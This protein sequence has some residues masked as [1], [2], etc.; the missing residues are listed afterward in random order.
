MVLL[1]TTVGAGIGL[2]IADGRAWGSLGFLYP[3]GG[4]F[5][6]T[7]GLVL[8]IALVQARTIV[9]VLRI[10]PSRRARLRGQLGS[11]AVMLPH[12]THELVW[13]TALSITAGI[14]EEFLFRGYLLWA[15]T[16]VIGQWGAVALSAVAFAL[17]HAY[18]GARGV[19]TTG[20]IAI[21]MT[22]VVFGSGSLYPA[23]ALHALIDIAQ[24][25]LAWLVLRETPAGEDG[26]AVSEETG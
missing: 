7:V 10:P 18:Q 24:G 17:A 14:C 4:W 8:A 1:W 3:G 22:L 25:L 2:W 20:A 21:V 5:W 19:L 9:K 12:S 6:G 11:L 23:I 15:F 16:P 13:F 26:I